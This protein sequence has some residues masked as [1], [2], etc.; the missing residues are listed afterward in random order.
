VTAA[1]LPETAHRADVGVAVQRAS[2]VLL[3]YQDQ[4]GWWPDRAVAGVSLAAEALLAR[5]FMR[6]GEAPGQDDAAELIRSSQ[7]AD[8]S[9]AGAEPGVTADLSASVLSYLALGLAGDSPDAYYMADAAGWIRDAGGIDAVGVTARAWLA[10]FGV[11]AWTDVPVPAPEVLW[12]PARGAP[13]CSPVVAVTLAILG[14]LRPVRAPGIGLA[15]LRASRPRVVTGDRRR[16]AGSLSAARFAARPAALRWCGGWLAGWQAHCGNPAGPRPAWPLSVVAL[17]AVGCRADDPPA[18]AGMLPVAHTAL[19]VDALR[20]AGLPADHPSIAAAGHWLLQCRIEAPA[21][22]AGA[23]GDAVPC[24]WSFC[25]DG[26]PRPADTAVVL[27]ALLGLEPAGS[28]V[29]TAATQWLAGKQDRDGGWDRSAEL[30][31]YCVR[32]LATCGADDPAA[33][34]AIRR[35]VVWLLRAQRS[36]GAWPGRGDGSDLLATSVVLPALLSARV[37]AGKP[38][39][40][41]GVGWLLAQQNA[42]GGWHLGG[43]GGPSGAAASDEAGT[44][45]V[46]TALMAAGRGSPA[47]GLAGAAAAAVNWLVRAQRADGGWAAPPGAGGPAAGILL[48]LAA[49][50]EYVAA[51]ES[52][53]LG[54]NLAVG[55]QDPPRNLPDHQYRPRR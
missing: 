48:P 55:L 47:S 2:R 37:R 24:G 30:T 44:S 13:S 8:G 50:G 54:G 19:A 9:W 6:A 33:K 23:Q 14:A 11:T 28:P 38:C 18:D 42:D 41:G 10:L 34:Q 27:R 49:L 7:R 36:S 25:P 12:L 40:T 20:A 43:V 5:W 35:G 15:E 16:S 39:I 31:G 29:I 51:G 1:S 17:H 4:A 21:L 22:R 3:A 26:Y 53:S 52:R 32:A 45:V 46:L